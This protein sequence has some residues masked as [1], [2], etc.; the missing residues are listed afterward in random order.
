MTERTLD[1]F[2]IFYFKKQKLC[3]PTTSHDL[4]VESQDNKIKFD[5]DFCNSIVNFEYEPIP[6]IKN[7]AFSKISNKNQT[8][9]TSHN[10]NFNLNLVSNNKY[11]KLKQMKHNQ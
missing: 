7:K 8:V 3:Q 11:T 6:R 2:P 1:Y 5:D 9:G 4:Q 10:Y